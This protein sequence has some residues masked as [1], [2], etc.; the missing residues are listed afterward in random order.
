MFGVNVSGS[1]IFLYKK[2]GDDAY[3]FTFQKGRLSKID[4]W[5][6]C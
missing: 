3:L 6:P 4:F 5:S 2:D 1:E